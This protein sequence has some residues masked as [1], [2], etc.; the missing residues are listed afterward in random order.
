MF[1]VND[2]LFW[3]IC[4]QVLSSAAREMKCRFHN[5]IVLGWNNNNNSIYVQHGME[6]RREKEANVILK[7]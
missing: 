7:R 6:Y 1:A 5:A 3:S 4:L 2:G